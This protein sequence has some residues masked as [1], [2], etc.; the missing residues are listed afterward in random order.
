[1]RRGR[2]AGR[3]AGA[4]AIT[5]AVLVGDLARPP[6]TEG[7]RRVRVGQAAPEITGGPWLNG[8]PRS[9]AGLRGR[10]VFVEFWTYG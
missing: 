7:Q 6:W 3:W 4:L 1:M 2:G 9:L 8:E 5:V 10:V